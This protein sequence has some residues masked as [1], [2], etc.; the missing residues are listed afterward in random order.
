MFSIVGATSPA[1][2]DRPL[3]LGESVEMEYGSVKAVIGNEQGK[4]EAYV[5][6]DE[7]PEFTMRLS[8]CSSTLSGY[9][10]D[11]G[12]SVSGDAEVDKRFVDFRTRPQNVSENLEVCVSGK[13]RRYVFVFDEYF[14]DIASRITVRRNS[15]DDATG[16]ELIFEGG[17]DAPRLSYNF[18]LDRV[19][20]ALCP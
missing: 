7:Q 10:F 5:S 12:L 6:R 18:D 14:G 19:L 15:V 2:A 11:V 1:S 8:S 13:C 20:G 9:E 4:P 17:D 16:V 3:Q